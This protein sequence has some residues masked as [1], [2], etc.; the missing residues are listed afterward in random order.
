MTT[1]PALV[2]FLYSSAQGPS[3]PFVVA[4]VL[5]FFLFDI[6]FIAFVFAMRIRTVRRLD[7]MIERNVRRQHPTPPRPVAADFYEPSR[8]TRQSA[9]DVL[10]LSSSEKA[11]E[12][13]K[14]NTCSIWYVHL[15]SLRRAC[16]LLLVLARVAISLRH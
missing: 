13:E 15:S 16:V 6:L 2:L 10:T 5:V 9:F 14:L 12:E 1:I 7:R 8:G 4:G 3:L 11:T